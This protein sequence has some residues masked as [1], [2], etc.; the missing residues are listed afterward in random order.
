MNASVATGVPAGL[1]GNRG[2]ALD[3]PDQGLSLSGW[4]RTRWNQNLS[5]LHGVGNTVWGSD[6]SNRVIAAAGIWAL[7][8]HIQGWRKTMKM[9][10]HGTEDFS[11][12]G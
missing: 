11:R 2:F 9:Q 12:V 6:A 3:R 10:D 8:H 4:C 7:D 1:C 5:M